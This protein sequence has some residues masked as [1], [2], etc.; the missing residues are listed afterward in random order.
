MTRWEVE[1][2]TADGKLR[3]WTSYTDDGP[4]A[5]VIPLKH[6]L[7]HPRLD[8]VTAVRLSRFAYVHRRERTMLLQTP[9]NGAEME[10]HHPWAGAML[11]AMTFDSTA[12]Q[13]AARAHVPVD[14]ASEFLNQLV[15]MSAAFPVA[16]DREAGLVLNALADWALEKGLPGMW[17]ADELRSTLAGLPWDR[18]DDHA[19]MI[20]EL[21]HDGTR[22]VDVSISIAVP[23][24]R[25]VLGGL[26]GEEFDVTPEG[27]Q[28]MGTFDLV[29]DV[30]F[31]ADAQDWTQR[32]LN[33]A[34]RESGGGP[35][36]QLAE[37]ADLRGLVEVLGAPQFLGSMERR[38][39]MRVLFPIVT[40]EHLM[41]IEKVLRE[42][43]V[44]ESVINRL[45]L[46]E[47]LLNATS[48][49]RLAV[50]AL[51]TTI[52][53]N[54]GIE[55]FIDPQVALVLPGVLDALGIETTVLDE[56]LTIVQQDPQFRD[57]MF[58]PGV[59]TDSQILQPLHVKV[60]F[61]PDG[62]VSAK[63]YISVR[64]APISTVGRT[65][66]DRLVPSTWEF[67]DLLF[68]SQTR[69]GRVRHRI[70]STDRFALANTHQI[71]V[72]PPP[73]GDVILP[74][75]DV[76]S[77]VQGDAPFGAVLRERA[78]MRDWTGP[79]ITF[80]AIA[81]L[82][83]RVQEI[84]PRTMDFTGE[85]M[86]WSGAPYPSGGA[87]YETDIV[88]IA[89]RVTGLEP[90]A[91][92]YRR[93][94]LSLQPLKG[95]TEKRDELLISAAGACGTGLVRPQALLVFAA[96]FPDLAVK[97]EGLAYSLMVKHV[98]VLMATVAYTATALG[99][100]SVPLGTGNSDVFAAATGLDY[101]RHGSIGEI[102]LTMP[103]PNM[104]HLSG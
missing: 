71:E 47:P 18:V 41:G 69:E 50:D 16:H 72:L 100:G 17:S 8:S 58:V 21:H 56:V 35:A 94:S 31:G 32:A 79:E 90:G 103:V 89:H 2:L 3:S 55:V 74:K 37:N 25:P 63:T 57:L 87:V 7:S 5:T 98:G 85:E 54:I 77:A 36:P 30:P 45:T 96:R 40:H 68:H 95:S 46:L 61:D 81:E 83:A 97:Y 84:V 75:I 51:D 52:L 70:G 44:A 53:P 102:A 88:L 13:L 93:A 27:A 29:R 67:H 49:M 65:Q 43:N 24:N 23:N 19:E 91:Y 39:G 28:R 9:L 92:L 12:E 20:L 15:A 99:L 22:R 60:A 86:P 42:S 26:R 38:S 14:A 73:P 62:R 34:V 1:R 101:Y 80:P 10:L 78:S 104:D 4:L 6:A 82:L 66:E 59:V 48:P 64:N 76:E 11:T 33:D